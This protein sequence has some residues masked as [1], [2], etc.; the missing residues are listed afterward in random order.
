MLLK[1][2]LQGS[3]KAMG[4]TIG[5]SLNDTW[6]P[7]SNKDMEEQPVRISKKLPAQKAEK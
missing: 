3:S 7:Y 6:K 2:Y 5:H 1:F 4:E